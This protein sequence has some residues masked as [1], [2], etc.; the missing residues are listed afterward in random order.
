MD[1][2]WKTLIR[3]VAPTIASAFGTPLAG[4]GVSALLNVLLPADAPKPADPEDFLAKTLAGAS[5]DL[6]M[7]IKEAEQQFKLD[8]KR[9]DVDLDK[10]SNEDRASARAREIAVKDRTP[11]ILAFAV[12][13]G[14]FGVLAYMLVADVPNTGHDAL[15]VMLGSLGTAWIAVVTYYFGSSSGSQAKTNTIA[16]MSARK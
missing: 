12:T 1:F 9:L 2:D 5:P 10:L 7:K 3:T 8:M 13:A 11:S 15:L 16:A 14:F 4:M 6:L